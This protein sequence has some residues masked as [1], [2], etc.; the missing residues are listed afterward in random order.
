MRLGGPVFG[1][2]DDPAEWVAA[3][4]AAGYRSAGCPV[5]ADAD[6][7]T[8]KAWA[9]AAAKAD[10]VIAETGAWSNPISS[11]PATAAKAMDLCK[12]QL[13]IAEKVRARCCVNIAG[14]RGEKWDGP[15]AADLTEET[16]DRIV[17]S[18][19]EI[20][21]AVKP[22][23]TAYTLETMPWMVPDST[24]AYVRLIEA[25]DR[26]A[27]AV[28]FDPVNIINC[29][30]RY[31]DTGRVIREFCAALGP[32]IRSCH[33]KDITMTPEFTTHLSEVAPGKGTL[34]YRTYLTE[35]ERIDPDMPLILEHMQPDEYPPAAEYVRKVAAEVGVSA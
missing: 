17:A 30:A 10:I 11:D 2:F 14:S 25:I 9:A 6:D 12:A 18:V 3:V 34:D 26:K 7:A 28:H 4:K 33:A 31:F 5:K 13:A 23:R 24:E 22:R 35:I 16:F 27:F 32:H 29:P 20:I 19:R 21:D 8:I 15:C 1:K